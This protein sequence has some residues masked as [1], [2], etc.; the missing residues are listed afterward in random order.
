MH[1]PIMKNSIVP[2]GLINWIVK[3]IMTEVMEDYV[4][5]IEAMVEKV[6]DY[7]KTSIELAKLQALDKTTEV[8]SSLV[9]H[10]I[11][12]ILTLIFLLFLNFGCALWLGEILGKIYYGFLIV[13]VFNGVIG[14]CVHFFMHKWLKKKVGDS[15]IKQVLK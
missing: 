12:L 11:V 8:V 9:P 3:I 4:K 15:F 2:R 6:T 10:G 1:M 14:I 5:L 13:A 7:G